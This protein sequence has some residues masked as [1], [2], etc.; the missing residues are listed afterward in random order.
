MQLS[1]GNRSLAVDRKVN[2]K[3]MEIRHGRTQK[4]SPLKSTQVSKGKNDTENTKKNLKKQTQLSD[5][6]FQELKTLF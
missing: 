4:V 6:H 3:I 2:A 1:C 5:L